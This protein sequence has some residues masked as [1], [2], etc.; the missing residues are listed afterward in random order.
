MASANRCKKPLKHHKNIGMLMPCRKCKPC[1]D[2]LRLEW[3]NRMKLECYGRARKPFFMT[4]TFRPE[5]YSDSEVGVKRDMAL[6]WKKLRKAGHEIRYFNVIERGSQRNRLHGHSILWSSTL[7]AVRPKVAYTLLRDVW[8]HGRIDMQILR[9]AGGL[10]Y[11]T[12]YLVKDLAEGSRNYQWS[13]KPMLGAAGLREWE[14]I[15][16]HYHEQ[17]VEFSR[18][19]LPPNY[20]DLP[21][22]GEI[23]RVY[24]PS[25][26]YM[27]FCKAIGIDFLQEKYQTPET[28]NPL[29]VKDGKSEPAIVLQANQYKLRKAKA[30]A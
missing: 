28:W 13:Q 4:W 29:E 12:K 25:S 3:T 22:Y 11:V 17:G 10:K 8:G 7:Q 9:S 15:I 23:D 21:F 30:A 19:N 26:A 18:D 16:H 2:Q 27:R 14:R 24:I 1:V 6:F 20:L 5:D